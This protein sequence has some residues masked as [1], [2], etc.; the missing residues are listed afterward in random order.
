MTNNSQRAYGI[1]ASDLEREKYAHRI[2]AANGEGRLTL[3]ETDR[4]LALVYDAIYR[5]E[6]E[7]LVADLPDE[8]ADPQNDE[9]SNSSSHQTRGQFSLHA[10]IVLVLSVFL[11]VRWSAS[12]AQFFW[13]VIPILWLV[14]TLIAHAWTRRFAFSDFK[15]A[16]ANFHRANSGAGR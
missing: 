8:P 13:P 10:L 7:W 11:V 15:F 16:W 3:A 5:H 1:R 14:T 6:L 12:G 4:R 2:E 9:P